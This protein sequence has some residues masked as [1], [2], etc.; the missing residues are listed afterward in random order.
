M[1]L[2]L[3]APFSCEDWLMATDRN[4]TLAPEGINTEHYV[5]GVVLFSLLGLWAIK[6]GFRGVSFGGAG[7]SVS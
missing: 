5:A 2:L 6:R 3:Q 7:V 4:A 1:T